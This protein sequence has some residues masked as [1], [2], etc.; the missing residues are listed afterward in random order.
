M[1][2]TKTGEVTED[3][4]AR[5]VSNKLMKHRQTGHGLKQAMVWH[6]STKN[7]KRKAG[8][9]T[10]KQYQKYLSDSFEVSLITVVRLEKGEACERETQTQ[11]SLT[12]Y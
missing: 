7:N 12:M 11:C 10:G 1:I 5:R 4:Q 8:K 9:Q 2:H 6:L 3:E